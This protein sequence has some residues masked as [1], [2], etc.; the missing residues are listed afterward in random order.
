MSELIDPIESTSPKEGVN[1]LRARF[2]NLGQSENKPTIRQNSPGRSSSPLRPLTPP[3]RRGPQRPPPPR[4]VRPPRPSDAPSPDREQVRSPVNQLRH[5][6]E[7][8][9]TNAMT[10]SLGDLNVIKKGKDSEQNSPSVGR[11]AV[12]EVDAPTKKEKNKRR[13][14]KSKDD[15]VEEGSGT[16]RKFWQ[17]SKSTDVKNSPKVVPD[18][19]KLSAPAEGHDLPHSVPKKE[20]LTAAPEVSSSESSSKEGTPESGRRK[21]ESWKRALKK[22][23]S[24][25]TELGSE[26]HKKHKKKGLIK[27][28]ST[29]AA[30][31]TGSESDMSSGTPRGSPWIGRKKEVRKTDLTKE[32]KRI[33]E[34]AVV[35]EG[36]F[37][38]I[39]YLEHITLAFDVYY[40]LEWM[41]SLI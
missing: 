41:R 15:L 33:K 27:S 30:V 32:A 26:G 40:I 23:E 24:D 8:P 11:A 29:L 10:R 21:S 13:K 3:V 20:P 39:L 35:N 12:E 28:K 5:N 19:R 25:V 37:H 38:L 18:K 7:H 31:D 6:Q 16:G 4:P 34:A 14:S 1:T 36:L 9:L 17:K 22:T 2:E